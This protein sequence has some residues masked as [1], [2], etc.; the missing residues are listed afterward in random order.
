MVPAG[1]ALAHVAAGGADAMSA[2]S[3]A[4]GSVLQASCL[5]ATGVL[6]LRVCASP[7]PQS[8]TEG[9]P[10]EVHRRA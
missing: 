10:S 2:V 5:L 9:I 4:F 6:F 3:V 1:V 8:V 7:V